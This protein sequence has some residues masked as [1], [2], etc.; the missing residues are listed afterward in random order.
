MSNTISNQF[1]ITALED[2]AT[3]H[4][5]LVSDKSLVQMWS[6]T[7]AVPNWGTTGTVGTSYQPTIHLTLLSGTSPVAVTSLSSYS[8]HYNDHGNDVAITFSD[9]S[10]TIE[11]NDTGGSGSVTGYLSTGDCAGMFLKHNKTVNGVSVPALRII[12]NLAS[13]SNVDVDTIT[14]VGAYNIG[15]SNVNFSADAVVRITAVTATGYIGVVSFVS[16][17]DITAPG[18]TIKMYGQLFNA[19]GGTVQC[20]TMWYV[21]QGTGTSGQIIDGYANAFSLSEDQVVDH[22]TIRCEFIYEGETVTVTYVAVDDIQDDEFMYIHY[23]TSQGAIAAGNPTSLRPGDTAYFAI[24]IG[25]RDNP[26]VLGGTETPR[27][28]VY[29]LKLLNSAGQEI[30][31]DADDA[32]PV[33]SDGYRPM[34]VVEGKAYVSFPYDTV[35]ANGKKMTGIVYAIS[36][37]QGA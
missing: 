18:Q 15:G 17:A 24:W 30:T 35:F 33:G 8:W 2:G 34:N 6:G 22:A 25:T 4:G 27:Y 7:A 21:N 32:R 3:L 10:T 14:F 16:S 36:E 1:M 11:W 37:S 28:S 29:K 12:S 13:T 20:S 23:G 26:A 5:N 19:T 9:T 31:G